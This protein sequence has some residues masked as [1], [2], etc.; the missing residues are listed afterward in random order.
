MMSLLP[1]SKL[2][3]CQFALVPF[4]VYIVA[5]PAVMIVN[6]VL[7]QSIFDIPLQR[8]RAGLFRVLE[9][10]YVGCDLVLLLG[11]VATY[12]RDKKAMRSA[13]VYLVLGIISMVFFYPGTI[14]SMTR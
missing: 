14:I 13:L 3:W 12:G 4:K 5:L 2:D 11:V 6:E 7:G 10:G 1:K 9:F 8:D